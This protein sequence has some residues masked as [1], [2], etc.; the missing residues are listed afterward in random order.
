MNWSGLI[1]RKIIGVIDEPDMKAVKR[2]I[3]DNGGFILV[4]VSKIWDENG[5]CLDDEAKP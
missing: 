1:D 2:I 5:E 4:P 3:F